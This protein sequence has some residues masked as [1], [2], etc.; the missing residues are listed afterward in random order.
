MARFKEE[1]CLT[2]LPFAIMAAFVACRRGKGRGEEET[3]AL[4][5]EMRGALDDTLLELRAARCSRAL[6]ALRRA[7]GATRA[8][9]TCC[10]AHRSVRWTPAE[11]GIYCQWPSC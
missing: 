4:S 9:T 1:T 10:L 5:R 11:A 6:P 3:P 2:L 8:T 7:A